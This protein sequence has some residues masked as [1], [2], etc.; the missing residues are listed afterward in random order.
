MSPVDPVDSVVQFLRSFPDLPR[1]VG[2]LNAREVGDPT[3]YAWLS[4]GF[5]ML[6]ESMDRA[7]IKYEVYH[8]DRET[9]SAI[10]FQAREYFLNDLPSSVAGDAFV[11]DVG[12]INLPYYDPDPTSREHVYCG[13][14]SLFYVKN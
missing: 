11:L 12:E 9:A 1:A 2:D 13:E 10:A 6:R 14:I 3:L 5:R 8:Q 4:G 7:D